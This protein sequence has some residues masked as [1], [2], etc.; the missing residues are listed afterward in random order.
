MRRD[1]TAL[2]HG[3]AKGVWWM[4]KGSRISIKLIL[5]EPGCEIP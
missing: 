2:L 5:L 4:Y 3:A 1:N